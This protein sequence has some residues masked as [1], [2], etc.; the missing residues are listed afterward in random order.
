MRHSILPFLILAAGTT[1]AAVVHVPIKSSLVLKPNEAYRITVDAKEP[2]EIGWQTVQARRCTSNCVQATDVTGG[3]N[4]TIA[5][6]MGASMKYTP[7]SGKISVEYKNISSESVTISIYRVQR[8]CEAEACTF[9][10]ESQKARWLVFKVDEFKSI[11]TSTDGSYSVISGVTMAGRR[12]SFR[13]VWWSDEK[14]ALIVD[15]SPF[16]KKYLDNHTP[17]E[18]YSPY[19]ISGQAIG[20]PAN[21]VL[22]SV[23]TCAPKAPNFGVPD[24]NVF[25]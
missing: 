18:Q 8:T 15:C 7:A 21:I 25:K 12:F 20:D 14:P 6:P 17:K 3:M 11:T 22:K 24:R 5:T 19:V 9:L 23:D 2:T 13:A 16:V 10:D 1:H 4:Y